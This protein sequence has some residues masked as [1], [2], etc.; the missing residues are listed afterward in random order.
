M[1]IPSK[2]HRPQRR[3]PH[4]P[5]PSRHT[6]PYRMTRVPW[7]V[8]AVHIPLSRSTPPRS[9]MISSSRLVAR[10]DVSYDLL[11]GLRRVRVDT[12]Q[13]DGPLVR[14]VGRRVERGGHRRRGKIG[15][16][17]VVRSSRVDR[18]RVGLV[19]ARSNQTRTFATHRGVDLAVVRVHEHQSEAVTA[20]SAAPTAMEQDNRSQVHLCTCARSQRSGGTQTRLIV[21]T[22]AP[23]RLPTHPVGMFASRSTSISPPKFL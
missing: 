20:V 9:C 14:R 11:R 5:V 18:E 4:R 3:S 17:V 2:L 12:V 15:L 7:R 10:A 6:S 21:M 22:T 23:S 13:R 1:I 16:G 8:R 19:S